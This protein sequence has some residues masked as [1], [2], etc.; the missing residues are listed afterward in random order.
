[1]KNDKGWTP[2]IIAIEEN[3]PDMVQLLLEMGA[4]LDIKYNNP[5]LSKKQIDAVQWAKLKQHREC[6]KILEK[7]KKEG[8]II[9]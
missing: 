9:S 5:E 3:E 2:L 7:A 8:C 6:H 1:M 4:K